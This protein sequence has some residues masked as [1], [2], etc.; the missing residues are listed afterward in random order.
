MASSRQTWRSTPIKIANDTPSWRTR[1]SLGPSKDG[2]RAA[3]QIATFFLPM[4]IGGDVLQD[5]CR[6]PDA[7]NSTF[8]L[9]Q[10]P[11]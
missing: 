7:K 2:A 9:G 3:H 11:T 6:R 8:D 4:L 5:G 1:K 10:Q